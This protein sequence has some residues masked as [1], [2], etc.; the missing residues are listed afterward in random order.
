MPLWGVASAV[1]S[2]SNCGPGA[3]SGGVGS[4]ATPLT[5]GLRFEEGLVVTTVAGGLA[6]V[7]GGGKF[8]NGAVTSSFGYLFNATLRFGGAADTPGVVGKAFSALFEWVT[9]INPPMDANGVAGGFVVQ[10][11]DSWSDIWGKKTPYDIGVY[12]TAAQG[13][14]T[15]TWKPSVGVELV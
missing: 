10:Y 13:E 15:V 11:P 14:N 7:A 5:N 8:G 6:S 1:A 2:G 9:G 12:G 4:F 3:L